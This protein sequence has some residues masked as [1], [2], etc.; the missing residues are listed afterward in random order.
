MA[1]CV[2]E[3]ENIN[4]A[5][6]GQLGKRRHCWRVSECVSGTAEKGGRGEEEG[7]NE[8]EGGRWGERNEIQR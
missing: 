3:I 4:T 8:G 2:V 7:G 6:L 1:V 5:G